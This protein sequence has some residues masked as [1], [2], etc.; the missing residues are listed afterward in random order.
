MCADGRG[1]G[2]GVEGG[3]SGD[4]VMGGECG[5]MSGSEGSLREALRQDRT[6]RLG[7]KRN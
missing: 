3:V 1:P 6:G 2:V 7:D 5:G 4:L